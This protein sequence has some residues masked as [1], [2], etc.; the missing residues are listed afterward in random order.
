MRFIKTT[1]L[2]LTITGFFIPGT[3]HSTKN[4]LCNPLSITVNYQASYRHRVRYVKTVLMNNWL[5]SVRTKPFLKTERIIKEWVALTVKKQVLRVKLTLKKRI[6][7]S[8]NILPETQNK[9]S[10]KMCYFAEIFNNKIKIR[11]KNTGNNQNLSLRFRM[12]FWV[13]MRASI[14][15]SLW[16][17]FI[18]S[19]ISFIYT[20]DLSPWLCTI[21]I[22]VILTITVLPE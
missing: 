11:Q 8:Q 21:R 10:K 15:S 16:L 3:G 2:C 4:W 6:S 12:T 13:L 22:S 18:G 7:G 14:S 9:L 5:L 1:V 20:R 19:C 17:T